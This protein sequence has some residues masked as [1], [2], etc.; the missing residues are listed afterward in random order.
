MLAKIILYA[1]LIL[2]GWILGICTAHGFKL[3]AVDDELKP[4]YNKYVTTFNTHCPSG[5]VR[6]YNPTNHR[7][8]QLAKIEKENIVGYCGYKLN[9]FIIEID[10]GFWNSI[11]DVT[12]THLMYHELTH[13]ILDKDHSKNPDNYMYLKIHKYISEEKLTTQLIEDINERC[14]N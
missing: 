6:N 11:D 12:K 9:G 14:E 8:I 4:F 10:R 13:C 7:I 3:E 1:N 5:K 2:L